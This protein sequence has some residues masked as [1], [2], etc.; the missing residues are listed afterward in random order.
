MPRVSNAWRNL[1]IAFMAAAMSR[2]SSRPV[3]NALW[4]RR[5][6]T[7]S[8]SRTIQFSGSVN[9]TAISR[10][11]FDPTSMAP[12]RTG[13]RLEVGSITSC[14]LERRLARRSGPRPLGAQGVVHQGVV[15]AP[16]GLTFG[17]VT[18]PVGPVGV[19]IPSE[20]VV[21][22]REIQHVAH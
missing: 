1:D 6:G 20:P 7:R 4:P 17:R 3:M 2:S 21:A 10:I 13:K 11:A 19:E 9:S 15:V 18:Q 14:N 22:E 8:E 16:D 5:T 12:R